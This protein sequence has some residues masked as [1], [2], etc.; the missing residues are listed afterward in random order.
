VIF[1]DTSAWY[2]REVEDDIKHNE[3]LEFGERLGRDEFGAIV[4]TDYVLDET[5]TLLRMRRGAEPALR[6]ARKVEGSRS[7]K[8]IWVDKSIFDYAL[9]ILAKSGDER[10]SFTDCTSFA[11]MRQLRIGK[12]FTF[13]EHFKTAGLQLLP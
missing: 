7:V 3:A 9:E 5:I 2:A 13:D 8:V 12:A 10:W 6:F 11:A 1:V 4:T